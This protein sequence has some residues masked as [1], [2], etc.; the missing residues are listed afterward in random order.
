MQPHD[1]ALLKRG[2]KLGQR[3]TWHMLDNPDWLPPSGSKLYGSVDY[4][5][6]APCAIY[7]HA[8]L[9]DGHVRTFW[10]SI[11]AGCTTKSRRRSSG[12]PSRE[13]VALRLCSHRFRKRR[14]SCPIGSD[15]TAMNL[16]EKMFS[17][18]TVQCTRKYTELLSKKL[19]RINGTSAS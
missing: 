2:L 14:N 13:D 8:T 4:G 3:V 7:L 16:V 19:M 6:G 12:R 11:N 10:S 17:G 5:F 9:P 1:T 15:M 18:R